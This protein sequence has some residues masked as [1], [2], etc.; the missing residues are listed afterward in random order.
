MPSALARY[1]LLLPVLSFIF[2]ILVISKCEKAERLLFKPL[3]P[4]VQEWI[5]TRSKVDV[6]LKSKTYCASQ[7]KNSHF[8]ADLLGWFE[9]EL[10]HPVDIQVRITRRGTGCEVAPGWT[11]RTRAQFQFPRR[12]LNPSS[13]DY[14][15][16]LK[17]QGISAVAY[18]AEAESLSPWGEGPGA[19]FRWA[20]SLRKRTLGLL[21]DSI[22][23]P[24][25]RGVLEALLV[26]EEGA[27]SPRVE[28]SF[29][30]TGLTHLLVV[31]GL[32]LTLLAFVFYL[33]A[34]L[35]FFL[36]GHWSHG[37]LAK[38]MA[39]ILALAPTTLYA[40]MVG[41]TPSVLRSLAFAFFGVFVLVNGWRRNF[42]SALLLTLMILL[43]WRPHSLFDL[44]FQLSFLS[45]I[46]LFYFG[47]AFRKAWNRKNRAVTWIVSA[48][49]VGGMVNLALLPLL[50]ASFHEVSL[51][52]P[53]TNLVFVPLYSGI[54]LPGGLFA[55]GLKVISPWWGGLCFKVLEELVHY[56][57]TA[58]QGISSLSFS[59]LIMAPL[60][61][62]G[63]AAYLFFLSGLLFL[64]QPRRLLLC[65]SIAMG[66]GGY[67]QIQKLSQP[68][69]TQLKLTML[70]VGQGDS[71]FLKLPDG[72]LLIIDGGGFPGS[73]F[74]LGRNVI[75]PELLERNHRKI[76]A[77]VMT[78]PDADHVKGFYVLA[79]RLQVD[80]FWLSSS[81]ENVAEFMPLKEILQ[82]N[83]I[84][85]RTL[86]KGERFN[87]GG[88]E[89]TVVW[90]KKQELELSENNRSLVMRACYGKVCF[91]L[92]GDIE[93]EAELSIAESGDSIQSHVLKVPHHG[94]RTSSTDNFLERAKP[95][96]ALISAGKR[97]RFR[98]PHS[99]VLDRLRDEKALVLRSDVHGQVE[100]ST[101]GESV[102]LK[103]F[104][105]G[106]IPSWWSANPRVI[107]ESGS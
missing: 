84:S 44:G 33:P 58:I 6:L 91:L 95:K 30:R 86:S 51:I 78:H 66:L 55:A 61:G 104:S 97:N 99:E 88:V 89:F 73:D 59:S 80:E 82:Q 100:I 32:H 21:R 40:L 53:L 39:M 3:P 18:V 105:S 101:D 92:T 11:Y 87:K 24:E 23:D 106:P 93:R 41:A 85:M 5:E 47:E 94:S 8:N 69:D 65:W 63:L 77:L 76:S 45:V 12:F 28:E 52:A 29:R 70:D 102:Y 96:L 49:Y 20:H 38:K 7:G 46:A 13:F 107:F 60:R 35:L 31:S 43:L 62:W 34:Y 72:E 14:P 83:N 67:V 42:L 74:D 36:K 90:P 48:V 54:L 37:G 79:Q 64:H 19:L 75:L 98:F 57:L 15:L 16:Y 25:V 4:T 81:F 9:G 2:G 10:F 1:P 50:A 17:R 68:V 56:S 27:L 26:G 22:E 71:F 103:T